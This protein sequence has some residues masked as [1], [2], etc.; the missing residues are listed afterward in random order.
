VI[1]IVEEHAA[2]AQRGKMALVAVLVE[3]DEEVGLVA[4]GQDVPGAHAHLKDGR[5]A[6][7]RGRN[8]HVRHDVLVAATSQ[9]GEETADR[10]NAVL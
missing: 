8:R 6:G 4:G 9:T 2:R 3:R 7:D 10:L 1:R 5:T